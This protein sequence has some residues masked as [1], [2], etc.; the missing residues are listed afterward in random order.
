M[1]K[2]LNVITLH[3]YCSGFAK[4]VKSSAVKQSSGLHICL[5]KQKVRSK[6]AGVTS[7][8]FQSCQGLSRAEAVSKK[9]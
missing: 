6:V 4:E 5:L 9:E 8:A 7:K 2:S 3:L 1:L